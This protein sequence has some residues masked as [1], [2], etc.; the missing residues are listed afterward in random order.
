M[1]EVAKLVFH[2]L[3]S[4]IVIFVLSGYWLQSR[5]KWLEDVYF[6]DEIPRFPSGKIL[7]R[8]LRQ[9]LAVHSVPGA[10]SVNQTPEVTGPTLTGSY[11]ATVTIIQP[12]D[13]ESSHSYAKDSP[14]GQ[15]LD[16]ENGHALLPNQAYSVALEPARCAREKVA[17]AAPTLFEGC[18]EW[19]S[20]YRILFVAVF[21]INGVGVGY[22]LAH[23]WD[24]GKKHTSTFALCNFTAALLA[25][26]ELF[27][28]MLYN[29]SLIF[30]KRWPP[31]WF[32][33]AIV[34]FLLH[35]GGLHSG[36]AMSG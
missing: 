13:A 2:S 36:F 11:D 1:F 14:Q 16:L 20:L 24:D 30:F 22:T 12:G 7:S 28:R 34:T 10:N 26:N 4:G 25:R 29:F 17:D 21:S 33:N 32:R 35:L 23:R 8:K 18:Q 9:Q 3:S 27:L 6:L 19:V 15:G 31:Y 5:Y